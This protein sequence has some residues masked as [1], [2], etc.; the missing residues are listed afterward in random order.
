MHKFHALDIT[1]TF[2]DINDNFNSK[3]SIKEDFRFPTINFL[4]DFDNKD[5]QNNSIEKTTF[6]NSKI[7][8]SY[9]WENSDSYEIEYGEMQKLIKDE[10]KCYGAEWV[11]FDLFDRAIKLIVNS[12]CY[13]NYVNDDKE[14]YTTNDSATDLINELQKTKKRH[15]KFKLEEKLKKLSY[16][17]I[18]YFGRKIEIESSE[19]EHSYELEPHWRRGHWRNQAIGQGLIERKLIWIKPTIVRKDKGEPEQGHIYEV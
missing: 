2:V 15:E 5:I 18:H 17:K 11:Q 14:F 10:D 13:L 7:Y 9:I 6:N 3:E 4:L 1:L 16:S 19:N 8:F 12:I